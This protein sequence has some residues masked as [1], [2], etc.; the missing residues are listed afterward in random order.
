[1]SSIAIA[2]IS[3]TDLI[4]VCGGQNGQPPAAKP[5][6]ITTGDVAEVGVKATKAVLNPLGTAA[7]NASQAYRQFN[8]PRIKDAG[9]GTRLLNGALGLFGINPLD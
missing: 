1:M 9:T 5:P 4:H 2:T 3:T 7:S 6:G 8:D